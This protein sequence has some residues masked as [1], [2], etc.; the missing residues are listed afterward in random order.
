MTEPQKW[1]EKKDVVTLIR[2]GEQERSA[3]ALKNDN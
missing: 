3:V 1:G 2:V